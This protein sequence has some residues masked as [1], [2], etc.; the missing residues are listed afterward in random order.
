MDKGLRSRLFGGSVDAN[1]AGEKDGVVGRCHRQKRAKTWAVAAVEEKTGRPEGAQPGNQNAAK[2]Q[3][4]TTVDNVHGRSKRP[5]GNS[6]ARA[7]RR[8]RKDRPDLHANYGV[9]AGFAGQPT[10]GAE[11]ALSPIGSRVRS[12]SAPQVLQCF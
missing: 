2:D 3:V 12:K 5:D 11:R 7:L 9:R 6:A 4:K 10:F 1:R 8:L